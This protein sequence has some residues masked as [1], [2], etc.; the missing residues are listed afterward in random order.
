MGY[1][2][3]KKQDIG[4]ISIKFLNKQILDYGRFTAVVMDFV[5]FNYKIRQNMRLLKWIVI[6][7]LP[8]LGCCSSGAKKE[9]PS[10]HSNN[11]KMIVYLNND[12]FQINWADL[13]KQD[14]YS[15]NVECINKLNPIV[16][17]SD[18]D[19]ISFNIK[20]NDTIRFYLLFKNNDNA[21]IEMIGVPK[22]VNFSEKYIHE[23]QEKISIEIPEVYELANILVAVSNIGQQDR[24]LV[25][26]STPYYKE[27]LKHFLS[28]SNLPFID[29]INHNIVGTDTKSYWYYYS[30]IM[31]SC[32]YMF[33]NSGHIVNKGIIRK[34][35]FNG[36]EDPFVKNA[37]LIE[38]FAFKSNFREFYNNHKSYYDSLIAVYN[39]LNPINK[40]RTWLEKKFKLEYGN[41]TVIF[42]PL[43]GGSHATN[44]FRDNGF[45][46]TFMFVCKAE[47]DPKYNSAINEMIASRVVFTE[48]DHNFVNPIS[49]KKL[50]IINRAF[51]IRNKWTSDISDKSSY[52]NA[53]SIFNE[54]MTWGLF[55]LYC[56]DS[57][58]DN[59]ARQ[60][61]PLMEI[62]MVSD[63]NFVRFKEFNQHLIKLYEGNHNI[64]IYDLYDSILKWCMDE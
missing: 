30:L 52:S 24:N 50:D 39:Q 3:R 6:F 10:L 22:N 53:C 31:N 32:G 20:I 37:K 46:Q 42:S 26:K 58:S 36:N 64:S 44:R 16:F 19:S 14:I 2:I 15:T 33:D 47:N 9:I 48:I 61:I 21:I 29:T 62:Q 35:G 45:E 38:D 11:R 43:V 41:Y 34:M 8:F 60:F 1:W 54:Y 25:D 51:S 28:Y 23:H 57:F 7:L 49:E 55:S 27:V 40:M 63:R 12:T 5:M 18:I 4:N 59:D 17:I 13:P 56:L